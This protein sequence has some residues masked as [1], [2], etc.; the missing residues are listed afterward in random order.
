MSFASRAST[1]INETTLEAGLLPPTRS[2]DAADAADTAAADAAAVAA[3]ETPRRLLLRQLIAEFT[4]TALLATCISLQ[5]GAA[6]I[7]FFLSALVFAF[8]HI[9]G[10]MFNPAVSLAVWLRGRM[11][12]KQAALYSF[13]QLLGAFVGGLFSLATSKA[14]SDKAILMPGFPMPNKDLMNIP[15]L[16]VFLCE[17]IGSF[18]LV[19]VVLNVATTKANEKN[20][21]YGFAIGAT[22]AMGALTVGGISGGAFN[23]AIGIALPLVAGHPDVSQVM[24]L[25]G[26]MLGGAAAAG[27]FRLIAS[28]ADLKDSRIHIQ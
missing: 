8:G 15:L 19:T 17:F 4:G 11:S 24:Y 9:S 16:A 27:L 6:A 26:P 14:V 3:A 12:L 23:P 2:S 21:F 25:I 7:G 22:V 18:A 13:V 1:E 28:P 20:S 10:G 5:A